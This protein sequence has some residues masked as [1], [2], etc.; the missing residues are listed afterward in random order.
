MLSGSSGKKDLA[1]NGFDPN[2]EVLVS[3]GDIISTGWPQAIIFAPSPHSPYDYNYWD[4]KPWMTL[5]NMA[6][7]RVFSLPIGKSKIS[8]TFAIRYR[9]NHPNKFACQSND[10]SYVQRVGP[11]V[12]TLK[13]THEICGLDTVTL[14]AGALNNVDYLWNTGE[15]SQ[16]IVAAVKGVYSVT[17][18]AVGT[19]CS[20]LDTTT[21][22]DVCVGLEENLEDGISIKL[23]PNPTSTT[24][25]LEV[26][27]AKNETTELSI[28][29]LLGSEVSQMRWNSVELKESVEIDISALPAG[30]YFFKVKNGES[31]STYRVIV[32]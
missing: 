19:N 26:N 15:V 11:I 29:N 1:P 31:F 3:Y 22:I 14:D 27:G 8:Y 24:I 13:D 25:N 28:I 6:R 5:K 32:E 17:V 20:N 12:I 10:T 21:V 18:T 9:Q 4:G 2:T 30:T 23:F 7:Y 16:T